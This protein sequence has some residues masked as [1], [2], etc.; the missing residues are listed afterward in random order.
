MPLQFP[1]HRITGGSFRCD[2]STAEPVFW[3]E[4]EWEETDD[5][6]NHTV[7]DEPEENVGHLSLVKA[8][9]ALPAVQE[10][11]KRLR[12][13]AM[14]QHAKNVVEAT[15]IASFVVLLSP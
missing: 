15:R 9:L 11:T 8:Y 2:N 14:K 7:T 1:V 6:G 13:T 10:K 3:I 4:V 5:A 12:A